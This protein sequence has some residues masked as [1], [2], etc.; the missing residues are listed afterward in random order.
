MDK[1]DIGMRSL[2][3]IQKYVRS[4]VTGIKLILKYNLLVIIVNI[5]ITITDEKTSVR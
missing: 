4:A 5:I 2:A 1:R 3:H